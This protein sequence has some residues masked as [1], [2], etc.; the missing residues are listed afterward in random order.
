MLAIEGSEQRLLSAAGPGPVI[1]SDRVVLVGHDRSRSTRFERHQIDELGLPVVTVDEVRAD[2]PAAAR[3]AL[4]LLAARADRYAIHLDVDVVDFTDAPL[5][6]HPS[7]N[8]GLKL[9][10][11][12]SALTVLTSG[13]GLVGLT[14]AELNPHNAAADAGLLDRFA[15]RF[16]D[17][18]APAAHGWA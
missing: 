1:G 4:D 10:E 17:V 5:S 18:I 2:P 11:M 6:V 14:L 8:V 13:P 3:R 15:A 16:A 9:D 12:L 7:R